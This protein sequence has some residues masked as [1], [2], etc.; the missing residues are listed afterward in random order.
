MGAP[1]SLWAHRVMSLRCGIWSVSG[2]FASDPP[3]RLGFT[4][5][6]CPIPVL[7]FG[8]AY[9]RSL[10]RGR[11]CQSARRRQGSFRNGRSPAGPD[12]PCRRQC[13]A[14]TAESFRRPPEIP[15]E[16]PARWTHRIDCRLGRVVRRRRRCRRDCPTTAGPD[17][18]RRPSDSCRSGHTTSMQVLPG[19][20]NQRGMSLMIGAFSAPIPAL[21]TS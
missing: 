16:D 18:A 20:R 7:I 1:V 19:H 9:A 21:D 2:T 3:G 10:G 11:A 15:R 17:A 4:P 13:S 14:A 8:R 6:V 5:S 12:H